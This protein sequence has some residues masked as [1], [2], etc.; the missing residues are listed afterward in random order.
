MK[1]TSVCI[2]SLGI[3]G[4]ANAQVGPNYTYDWRTIDS[5][6]Q[7]ALQTVNDRGD[8]FGFYQNSNGTQDAF[9]YNGT[10]GFQNFALTNDDIVFSKLTSSGSVYSKNTAATQQLFDAGGIYRT[11]LGGTKSQIDLTNGGTLTLGQ[12][13]QNM[14]VGDDDRV[15][16]DSGGHRYVWSPISGTMDLGVGS[17]QNYHLGI[18]GSIYFIDAG[19]TI[20]KIAADGTQTTINRPSATASFGFILG[21]EELAS[22]TQKFSFLNPGSTTYLTDYVIPADGTKPAYAVQNYRNNISGTGGGSRI[23]GLNQNGYS[24]IAANQ[25]G[26]YFENPG[27]YDITNGIGTT[28]SG[29]PISALDGSSDYLIGTA[30]LP[31][32]NTPTYV[33][34]RYTGTPSAVP[35]PASL[36]VLGLGALALLRRRKRA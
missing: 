17:S 36:A 22:G 4:T 28:F 2:I 8:V 6:R 3:I 21:F 11:T 35:E 19:T 31:G 18:N 10:G 23:I 33:L 16:F 25:P 14:E 13:I 26:S 7:L 29:L 32:S 1:R 34:G 20:T 30:F 24:A 9:M 15:M 5:S 27:L 12:Y